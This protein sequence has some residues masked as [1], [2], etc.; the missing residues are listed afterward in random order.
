MII[1]VYGYQDSGKTTLV[2]EL[3]RA[4]VRGG[5]RVSSIKHTPHDKTLDTEGKDTWRHWK[6]GSDPVAFSSETETTIIKHS[7]S[8]ADDIARIIMAEYRPDCPDR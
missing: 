2:E 4:L 7:K 5:Y 3:V 6:A 1:G 8:S